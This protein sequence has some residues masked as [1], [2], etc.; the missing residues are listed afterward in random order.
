MKIA[1]VDSSYV[2][3]VTGAYYSERHKTV[4]CVE[5]GL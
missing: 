5:I 2:G 3:L 4:I 1:V